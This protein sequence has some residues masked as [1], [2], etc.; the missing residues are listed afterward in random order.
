MTRISIFPRMTKENPWFFSTASRDGWRRPPNR[1]AA[2]PSLFTHFMWV[3]LL[4]AEGENNFLFIVIPMWEFYDFSLFFK[5]L[6][7]N[8]SLLALVAL[9]LWALVQSERQAYCLSSTHVSTNSC[10]STLCY[11]LWPQLSLVGL[12]NY[13]LI[14]NW[15]S[16]SSGYVCGAGRY[17]DKAGDSRTRADITRNTPTFTKYQ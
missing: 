12:Y 14:R 3:L 6:S 1:I 11:Q 16:H 17:D 9:Q 7:E 10:T 4:Y 2:L 8:Y 15:H 13:L 5:S